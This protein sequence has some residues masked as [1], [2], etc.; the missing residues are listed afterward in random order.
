MIVT[1]TA[2]AKMKSLREIRALAKQVALRYDAY[3]KA[4]HPNLAAKIA[5]RRAHSAAIVTLAD[6]QRAHLD[7]FGGGALPMYTA[8]G[9]PR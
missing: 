6:T 1:P 8:Q 7:A 4:T 9:T 3:Y 2:S 5:A